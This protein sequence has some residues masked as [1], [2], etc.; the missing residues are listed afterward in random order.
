MEIQLAN[1]ARIDLPLHLFSSKSSS[2]KGRAHVKLFGTL[3]M[4]LQKI[5]LGPCP[6]AFVYSLV[7]REKHRSERSWAAFCQFCFLLLLL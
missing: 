6:C 4:A 7:G 5:R 3:F 1:T 2:S